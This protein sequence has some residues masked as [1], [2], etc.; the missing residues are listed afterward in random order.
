M[1]IKIEVS[2]ERAEEYL[3]IDDLIGLDE[4]DDQSMQVSDLKVIKSA[5]GKF[6]VDENGE[7]L[8]PEEGMALL[9]KASPKQLTEA[10]GSFMTK[11][12]DA[13]SPKDNGIS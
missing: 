8:D 10:L 11:I 6:V 5:L 2:A 4:I 9:G 13:A 12:E 3:S 7:Y 1:Q